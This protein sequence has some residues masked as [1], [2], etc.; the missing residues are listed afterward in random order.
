MEQNLDME[1]IFPSHLKILVYLS[2]L[3]LVTSRIKRIASSYF[4][5]SDNKI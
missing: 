4:S 5:K 2:S 3:T 1:N